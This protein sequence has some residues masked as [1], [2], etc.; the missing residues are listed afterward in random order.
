[1][2]LHSF[3][4]RFAYLTISTHAHHKADWAKDLVPWAVFEFWAEFLV[5]GFLVGTFVNLPHAHRVYAR[6][7]HGIVHF[8][9][10]QHRNKFGFPLIP[11]PK[12]RP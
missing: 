7:V 10:A 12:Q 3:V 5:C 1:M 11:Q 6:T 2:Y 8:C 9:D 4:L